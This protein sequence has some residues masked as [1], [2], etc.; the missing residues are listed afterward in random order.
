[1]THVME[2]DFAFPG[3]QQDNSVF[4]IGQVSF[5]YFQEILTN[6]FGFVHITKSCN[7]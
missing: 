6:F 3:S 5:F 7:Y 1:M 4:Q 2:L